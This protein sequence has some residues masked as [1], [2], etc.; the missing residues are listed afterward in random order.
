M[1]NEHFNKHYLVVG[2][3][4]GI[5]ENVALE[6]SS[7]GANISMLSRRFEKME[8]VKEK[9]Q[10]G[11]HAIYSFD[12]TRL[13]D[14]SKIVKQIID[15]RGVLDG[16]VYSAGMANT[17]RLRDLTLDL[18]Q[19]AMSTNF[20]AF[21]EFIRQ[22]VKLKPRSH[23]LRIVAISSLASITSDRY[24]TPY[25]ASKAA[26]DAAIRC[27]SK[28]LITRNA[29]INSIRPAVVDVERLQSLDSI[30]ISLDEEIKK[31]G[32]QPLGMIPPQDVAKMVAYLM[33]DATKF[34]TG[35]S[36]FINGGAS[37]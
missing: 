25:S 7:Y 36:V 26:M 6:L 9:M 32:F 17:A 29:T 35:T 37:C 14:I 2:A 15:E 3:S 10:K 21:V 27:L 23:P 31:N 22:I 34:V 13:N 20:F 8:Q 1:E 12:V 28:E 19:E 4:S 30:G 33:S 11:N 18:Q 16:F 5:G 24:H